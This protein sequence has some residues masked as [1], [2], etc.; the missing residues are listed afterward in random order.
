MLLVL[1][2]VHFVL[3][4]VEAS[5]AA[6]RPVVAVF[7]AVGDEVGALAES[8]PTHLADVRFLT[9]VDEGVFLHV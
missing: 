9:C 3:E 5:R 8:F 4:A 2:Q 1:P 7:A 6:V